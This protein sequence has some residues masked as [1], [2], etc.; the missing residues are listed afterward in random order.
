MNTPYQ[1]QY[2]AFA[3]AGGLYDERH[4]KLYAEFADNLIADGSFSIVYEGV[5]H[6]CY[7]PIV[8]DAAP[9]LKCYVLAPLAVL[10]EFQG[11]GY[12]TRLMEEAEK[13][14]NADV[15]FVMG[16]PMHYANR[17]NTT[18]SVLL[19]VPS[20]APLDCWFARELTPGA[21][22][23]VG[24]STSSIKG[25]FSDPLMWSHPDEQVV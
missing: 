2:E 4:A 10:P 17:Y 21:L 8:I 16:D 22:T 20:N 6:A 13:Q 25:P 7:T 5:A 24:E 14:L 23:G 15:I 18:H 3:K 11:K 12:A 19:P 9:H 1:I